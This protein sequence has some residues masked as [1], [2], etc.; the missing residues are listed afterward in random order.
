MAARSFCTN[1]GPLDAVARVFREIRSEVPVP[2]G[3]LIFVSGA[4]TQQLPAL[5][6]RLRTAWKGVPTC[7]VPGAGV[8]H[9]RGEI[10]GTPAVAG[11]LWNG[12]QVT[13]FAQGSSEEPGYALGE[14]IGRSLGPRPGTTLLFHR[15]EGFD[16]ALLEGLAAAAPG[17]T[18]FGAG[19]VGSAALGLTAEGEILSGRVVG[20]SLTGLASPIVATSPACRL[21]TEFRTV[22]EVSGGLVLRLGE[23]T[24]LEELSSA[25]P[26]IGTSGGGGGQP[27]VFAALAEEELRE[28]GRPRFVVRPVRGIDPTRRGVMIG[29]EVRPGMRLC[30]GVRDPAAAK[31][32]LEA[33]ARHVAQ[34]TL[35]AAPRFAIYLSCAGRGHGLYGTTDVETRIL[36]QRFGDLPMAGMHSAFEIAPRK[37]G[38][39][40]LELYTGVLALFRSPS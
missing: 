16:G 14:A 26:G 7:I 34:N 15:P 21:V 32:E 18:V 39:A 9:E 24:A 31:A 30:F 12:G 17:A 25:A 11:L 13:T 1:A 3:G 38:P 29:S 5:A 27:L 22:E 35:G 37:S 4:L 6:Q 8:L 36:R 28:D 10:E 23:R 2:T 33:M 40:R 19:T 20:M